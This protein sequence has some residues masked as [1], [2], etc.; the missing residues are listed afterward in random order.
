MG[1]SRLERFSTFD[2]PASRPSR[3]VWM[4]FDS[5]KTRSRVGPASDRVARHLDQPRLVLLVGEGPE[6][7]EKEGAAAGDRLG[8]AGLGV[9]G[10]VALEAVDAGVEVLLVDELVEAAHL[11]AHRQLRDQRRRELARL[12]AVPPELAQLLEELADLDLAREEVGIPARVAVKADLVADVAVEG[13][14]PEHLGDDVR[15]AAPGPAHEDERRRAARG[16]RLGRARGRV[17]GSLFGHLDRHGWASRLTTF[18]GDPGAPTGVI[19]PAKT[20]PRSVRRHPRAG[21]PH[22][23]RDGSRPARRPTCRARRRAAPGGRRAAAGAPLSRPA[24]PP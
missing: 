21:S 11:A 15:A 1:C 5:G 18:R 6:E 13:V 2:D 8:G 9:G 20:S 22:R 17:G 7:V 4:N 3:T 16:A 24:R 23:P 14:A 10:I 12:D 19:S